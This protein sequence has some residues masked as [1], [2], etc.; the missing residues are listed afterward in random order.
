MCDIWKDNQRL[1]QLTEEDIKSLLV[2]F[3]KFGTQ[4]VV[5]SGGEALL[6]SKFFRFCEL[7]KK[8]NIKIVLLSTGLTL[9]NNA[10]PLTE[11]VDEIIDL[12]PT[13]RG[14]DFS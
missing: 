11:L 6:N 7:L 5:M 8:E 14:C 2:P 3:R 12:V 13:L 4:Q 10:G 1:K 9:K